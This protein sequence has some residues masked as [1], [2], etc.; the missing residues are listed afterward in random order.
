M[1]VKKKLTLLL[2]VAIISGIVLFPGYRRIYELREKNREHERRI[3]LLEENNQKLRDELIR[4][5]EDPDYL[6]KKARNKLGIIK[7]GEMIYSPR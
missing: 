2:L 1:A 5:K 4:L 6:E 7:D 3:E